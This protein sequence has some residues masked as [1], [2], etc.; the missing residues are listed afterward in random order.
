MQGGRGRGRRG[1]FLDSGRMGDGNGLAFGFD[2]GI[3]LSTYASVL[4]VMTLGLHS[5]RL[6]PRM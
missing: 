3:A 2:A 6:A 1:G 4:T 5:C